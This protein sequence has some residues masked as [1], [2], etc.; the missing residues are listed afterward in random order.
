M[1]VTTMIKWGTLLPWFVVFSR[2]RKIRSIAILA[3]PNWDLSTVKS[4]SGYRPINSNSL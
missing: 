3:I 2:F 1:T 4:S